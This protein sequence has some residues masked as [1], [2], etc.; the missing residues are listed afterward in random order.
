MNQVN[1]V[2][3]LGMQLDER[4]TCNKKRR[5]KE[6]GIKL[7]QLYRF[8]GKKSQLNLENKLLQ[9]ESILNPIWTY[10]IQL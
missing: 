5:K 3:Y 9:Y 10:G 2:K 6:L 7:H 8:I 1:I 4:L